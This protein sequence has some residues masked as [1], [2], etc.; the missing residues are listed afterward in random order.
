MTSNVDL[1]TLVILAYRE[2]KDNRKAIELN[3]RKVYN[4]A[5]EM[6]GRNVLTIKPNGRNVLVM[7]L[8]GKTM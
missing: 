1:S 3:G 7:E 2:I 4:V 6:N 5:T 8:N